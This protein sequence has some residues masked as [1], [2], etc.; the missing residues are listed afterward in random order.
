L[1]KQQGKL[2][3]RSKAEEKAELTKL[4]AAHPL[5]TWSDWLQGRAGKGDLTA[6][7]ILR[8]RAE[9]QERTTAALLQA[10]TPGATM[11]IIMRS[12]QPV[13][14]RDGRVSYRLIDGGQV[15][16]RADKVL[17][18]KESRAAATLA[19]SLAAT[20]F[21]HRPLAVEGSPEFRRWVGEDARR[22]KVRLADPTLGLEPEPDRLKPS[23]ERL[24]DERPGSPEKPSSPYQRWSAGLEGE[25]TYLGLK[26]GPAGPS[27]VWRQGKALFA[28]AATPKAQLAAHDVEPG[29]RVIFFN[30]NPLIIESRDRDGGRNTG[31]DR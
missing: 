8:S 26:D 11:A 31:R 22:L 3:E 4:H 28:Q 9:R 10:T 6:L 12:R 29:D 25:F 16:D 21:G 23:G 18:P 27:L 20:R 5:P 13:V 1:A 19:V 24:P 14:G 7:D 30:G 17:V 15:E 2:F